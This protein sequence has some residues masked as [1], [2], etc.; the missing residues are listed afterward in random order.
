MLHTHL[1]GLYRWQIATPIK[2]Q[3]CLMK[4]KE[5]TRIL[6][7]MP[8]SCSP[9]NTVNHLISYSLQSVTMVDNPTHL[10]QEPACTQLALEPAH[11]FKM[12]P[13]PLGR[14]LC[15][16]KHR[17]CL[18]PSHQL[19]AL[20]S[21]QIPYQVPILLALCQVPILLALY[22]VP[23]LLALCLVP[24]LWALCFIQVRALCLIPFTQQ[25]P[26]VVQRPVCL[27]LTRAPVM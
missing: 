16:H 3:R 1:Q 19:Q 4:H 21:I 9:V 24:I 13:R 22:Q 26:V 11:P 14:E 18:I 10:N 23:I 7:H 20:C 12:E 27:I 17:D 8:P 15:L 25:F 5:L 2:P 6:P